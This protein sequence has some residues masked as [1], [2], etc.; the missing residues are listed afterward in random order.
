MVPDGHLQR[1]TTKLSAIPN[2]F[3]KAASRLSSCE[4]LIKYWY[5]T[6]LSPNDYPLGIIP[7]ASGKLIENDFVPVYRHIT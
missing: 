6:E 4:V 1:N 3:T 2:E 5:N 7:P